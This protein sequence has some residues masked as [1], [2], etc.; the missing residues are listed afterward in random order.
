MSLGGVSDTGD[1]Y[2]NVK[3][4]LMALKGSKKTQNSP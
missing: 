4:E 3:G 1:F 2:G